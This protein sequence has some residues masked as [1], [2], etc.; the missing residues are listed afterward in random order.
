M[1]FFPVAAHCCTTWGDELLVLVANTFELDE[2]AMV[3]EALKKIKFNLVYYL[4]KI[5]QIDKL[6]NIEVDGAV[7]FIKFS[8]I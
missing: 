1:I 2:W 5:V 8:I 4:V 7:H 6:W 3:A